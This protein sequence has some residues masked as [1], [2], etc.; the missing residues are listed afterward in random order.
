M[1]RE[2]LN[3]EYQTSK[4]LDK[5]IEHLRRVD[6]AGRLFAFD[7]PSLVLLLRLCFN[8][9][10]AKY[11]MNLL[12]DQTRNLLVNSFIL[13][14]DS[15][16]FV[17]HQHN[18]KRYSIEPSMTH[19]KRKPY[20]LQK[21]KCHSKEYIKCETCGYQGINVHIKKEQRNEKSKTKMQKRSK[22]VKK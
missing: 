18:N 17:T 19:Q 1:S 10:V 16:G 12:K 6:Y 22:I 9:F 20:T 15:L 21:R 3:Q 14:I 4:R 11:P 2:A 7:G 5:R 8:L 13:N